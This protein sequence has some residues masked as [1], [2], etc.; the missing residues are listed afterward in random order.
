MIDLPPLPPG[1]LKIN[2]IFGTTH[3]YSQ[4][5]ARSYG[6]ACA[7]AERARQKAY[8]GQ[9]IAELKAGLASMRELYE[10]ETGRMLP[11]EEGQ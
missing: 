9:Y 5:E 2:S 3:R 10:R 7:L 4:A 6:E 11:K 1:S 8:Y